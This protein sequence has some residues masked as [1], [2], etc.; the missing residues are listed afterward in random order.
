MN[1]FTEVSGL[2]LNLGKTEAIGLGSLKDTPDGCRGISWPKQ[3]IRCLG[4]YVGHN[5]FE[6]HKQNWTNKIEKI[7]KA[8]RPVE[9]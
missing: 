6:C 4:I 1:K 7:P 2:K 5:K 8:P 9:N 3:A